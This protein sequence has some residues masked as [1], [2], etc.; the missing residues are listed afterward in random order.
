M[1]RNICLEYVFSEFL[2][3]PKLAYIQLCDS[4]A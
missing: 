4:L 3:S 1:L 2:L